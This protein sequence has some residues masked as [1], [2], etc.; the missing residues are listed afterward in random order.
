M[1]QERQEYT[2]YSY[3]APDGRRYIGKTGLAQHAREQLNGRGY[4]H[5]GRFWSAI[6]RHGWEAFRYE[7]LEVIPKSTPNAAQLACEREAYYINKFKTTNI[8]FG[9]NVQK[10]DKPRNYTKL[11]I[12]RQSMRPIH[13]GM[14]NKQ[15]H[16][17]DY[18]T[19]LKNGWEP[20][21]YRVS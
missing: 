10:S 16:V 20:G 1:Y 7:V 6:K 15:V 3:I 9:F 4:A 8:R 2:I 13:K 18:D 17:D 21:Y 11:S 5:C 19:Y 12:V 14:R